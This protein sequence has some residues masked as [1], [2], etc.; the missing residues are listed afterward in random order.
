VELH[1]H[2]HTHA[3]PEVIQLLKELKTLNI[4]NMAKTKQ[5][6]K[7]LKADLQGSLANLAA[8]IERLANQN[9]RTDLTEAEEQEIFDDFNEIATALRSL[10]GQT[11]EPETPPTPEA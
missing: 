3:D 8:D 4:Q 2:L 11:P 1:I 6:F 7:D 9:Q 10:A 5:E